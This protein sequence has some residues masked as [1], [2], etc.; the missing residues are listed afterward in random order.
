MMP[1]VRRRSSQ[2]SKL[3]LVAR[4]VAS[5]TRMSAMMSAT[6]RCAAR[7][8]ARPCAAPRVAHPATSISRRTRP[9]SLNSIVISTATG[10]VHRLSD[11]ADV[12]RR[13]L[14]LP[15]LIAVEIAQLHGLHAAEQVLH[16][17][18]GALHGVERGGVAALEHV[19]DQ[20]VGHPLQR[21]A[22]LPAVF[23]QPARVS[24]A[25]GNRGGAR[26]AAELD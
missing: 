6:P 4:M 7:A 18:L 15:G 22:L 5:A 20:G 13:P 14:A 26:I 1:M 21:A 11:G 8:R 25:S 2:P 17:R 12:G 9:Q 19:V 24:S 10:R 3:S 23:D 16:L